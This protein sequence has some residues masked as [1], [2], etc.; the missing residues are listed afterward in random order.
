MKHMEIKGSFPL[1]YT[2]MK[3]LIFGLSGSGK[4]TLANELNKQ[5][6]FTR[7]NA[8]DIRK[9]W[10]DWDF[11]MAGR[12]RQAKRLKELADNTNNSITDFIAPT[13]NIRD[14]F[15]ADITIWMDTV[16]NSKY[17]DTDTL[18]EKPLNI[19]YHVTDKDATKWAELIFKETEWTFKM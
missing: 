6:Q 5:I 16:D 1:L 15:D 11:S 7:I 18:F 4:T 3:I 17:K 19:C 10:N 14:I 12:L 13:Q 2:N 8:D 9:K